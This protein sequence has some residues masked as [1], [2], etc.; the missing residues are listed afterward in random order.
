MAN[1][2]VSILSWGRWSCSS[3][4][5]LF[6]EVSKGNAGDSKISLN[7]NQC[8]QPLNAQNNI[9]SLYR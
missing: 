7:G 8:A 2:V 5:D 1:L 6:V 9:C 4:G 3:E